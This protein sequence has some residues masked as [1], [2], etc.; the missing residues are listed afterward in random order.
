MRQAI[1]SSYS[2]Y[3][4]IHT[5]KSYEKTASLWVA[6]GS[7]QISYHINTML[8]RRLGQAY[9]EATFVM[10]DAFHLT[11]RSLLLHQ[12]Y[13]L[14]GNVAC[15]SWRIV[16]C[17]LLMTFT[18]RSLYW[19]LKNFICRLPLTLLHWFDSVISIFSIPLLVDLLLSEA[20]FRPQ[21]QASVVILQLLAVQLSVIK[22]TSH[23]FV[24]TTRVL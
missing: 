18:F 22:Y 2:I 13:W 7:I 9:I 12:Y 4:S 1:R 11:V 5:M 19:L 15:Y 24:G 14:G 10:Y 17:H 6:I 16:Y 21:K 20:K 23:D 3:V 8:Y